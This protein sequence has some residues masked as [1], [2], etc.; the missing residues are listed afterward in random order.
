MARADSGFAPGCALTTH[1]FFL[2]KSCSIRCSEQSS[3]TSAGGPGDRLARCGVLALNG[4][5]C[6]IA[7]SERPHPHH[8]GGQRLR[9]P[10]G[11][12]GPALAQHP[13]A[14]LP[15]EHQRGEGSALLQGAATCAD[16][17][18]KRSSSTAARQ[19]A[20]ELLPGFCMSGN[21]AVPLR[22]NLGGQGT[23]AAVAEG[24]RG[25]R[26]VDRADACLGQRSN[27]STSRRRGRRSPWHSSP[28][29]L[30][31]SAN[32]SRWTHLQGPSTSEAMIDRTW[33][34]IHARGVPTQSI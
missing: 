14:G 20:I 23:D 31:A 19:T 3:G 4:V 25:R 5:V 34:G 1:E 7:T 2:S 30:T 32:S 12:P 11:R 29:R 33:G 26:L 13:S 15:T 9:H 10:R 16:A 18:S 24:F 8:S 27:L 22:V 28:A 21:R 6:C 17:S